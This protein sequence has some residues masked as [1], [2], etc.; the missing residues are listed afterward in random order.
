MN[1][2]LPHFRTLLDDFA[3]EVGMA[4]CPID[5][6]GVCTLLFKKRWIVNIAQRT[7][8]EEILL[9]ASLGELPAEGRTKLLC[10]M[11]ATNDAPQ[12]TTTVLTLARDRRTAVAFSRAKL[13]DLNLTDFDKWIRSFLEVVRT[14][15][16]K[17]HEGM[18]TVPAFD[19]PVSPAVHQFLRG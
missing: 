2:V 7:Q 6:D 17:Y 10:S 16:P 11:L 14:W 4:T 3:T 13:G 5:E 19:R 12:E 15:A 1:P 9:F 8:R 18:P